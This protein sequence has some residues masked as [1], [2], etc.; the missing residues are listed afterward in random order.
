MVRREYNAKIPPSANLYPATSEA[1]L[2]DPV[3]GVR[4]GVALAQA[5][6]VGS[7]APGELEFVLDR[8]TTRDDNRGLQQS[9]NDNLPAESSY[10]VFVEQVDEDV[11]HDVVSPLASRIAR[12]MEHPVSRATQSSNARSI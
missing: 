2:H 6:A 1:Y 5:N 9:L 3:S 4:L 11:A 8:R 10:R 7:M 12:E